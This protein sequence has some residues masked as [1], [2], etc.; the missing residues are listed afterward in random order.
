MD[1]HATSGWGG[2]S[3]GDANR[4]IDTPDRR[5]GKERETR[6]RTMKS[7]PI[8]EALHEDHR[9]M[10]DMLLVVE[11]EIEN[12]MAG[13][14]P[15]FEI[16]LA[17]VEYCHAYPGARHH[18][19]EDV[20]FRYL[21]TRDSEAAN[22]MGDLDTEHKIL[23]DYTRQFKQ[24]IDQ[25]LNEEVVP[26]DTLG[27]LAEEYATF[28]KGHMQAEETRFFPAAAAALTG[29][30][31]GVIQAEVDTMKEMDPDPDT[32]ARFARLRRFTGTEAS[33]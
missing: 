4:T 8:I 7:N 23:G 29:E 9:V 33:A 26:K 10:R 32:E 1:R 20:V 5:V 6:E 12:F 25:I 27:K 13:R 15:D 24:A 21:K 14:V 17:A 31:W 22:D 28:L 16:M 18:P 11:G 2:K 30:D 3:G 19:V